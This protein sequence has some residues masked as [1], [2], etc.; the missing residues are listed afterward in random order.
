[1]VVEAGGYHA[2]A[3]RLFITQSA[4][5]Q[6]VQALE[7]RLGQR[8]FVR[9][10]RGVALTPAGETLARFCRAQREAEAGLMAQLG[11]ED[12]R[13]AGRLAVAAGTSEGRLW[14]LPAVAALA[15]AHPALDVTVT[16]DDS[17]DAAALLEASRVDAVL[18]ETPLRRR[19][20]RST[21]IGQVSYRMAGTYDDWPD[22]PTPEALLE[23]RAIDFEPHDRI[24]L[25][26]LA[27][28]LPGTDLG[29]LRRHFVNDTHGILALTLAGGGFAVLPEVV[30]RPH[31]GV[32]R[33]FYPQVESQRTL[34]WSVPEGQMAPAVRA[35]RQLI[36]LAN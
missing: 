33:L 26:H 6:R 28:C 29:A 3:D 20:L 2:A 10:G 4:V 34:Y 30:L 11:G 32:L 27:L 18:G 25:D 19:G 9:A 21:A 16:L 12:G 24:T 22:A 13:L 8:L 17:L 14:L 7:G 23:R 35:L 15:R 1:M 31:L 36:K 5:T